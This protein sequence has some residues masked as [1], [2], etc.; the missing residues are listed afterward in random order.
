[1]TY[2]FDYS[3][4]WSYLGY[5]QLEKT[6]QSVSP[7]AVTVEWVPLLLGA[8]FRTIGTPNVRISGWGRW[9]WHILVYWDLIMSRC[10]LVVS[11]RIRNYYSL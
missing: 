4:P 9:V 6:V 7:V 1:M 11:E 2:Y 10:G 5:E 8:L 3:S